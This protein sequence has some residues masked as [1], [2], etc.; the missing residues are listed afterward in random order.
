[1]PFDAVMPSPGTSRW[2][3][4]AD[5]ED[6]RGKVEG[7]KTGG[8]GDDRARSPPP[9][10]RD[11]RSQ[12]AVTASQSGR[13]SQRTLERTDRLEETFGILRTMIGT[14]RNV[15]VLQLAERI[16]GITEVANT[17]PNEIHSPDFPSNGL[18][19]DPAR[20][21]SSWMST[22]EHSRVFWW[23]VDIHQAEAH[24]F[25]KLDPVPAAICAMALLAGESRV[26]AQ[27]VDNCRGY[28]YCF[29][30]IP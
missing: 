10:S 20:P 1:M 24:R 8:E 14:D 6:D 15:D 12:E 30:H 21:G 23:L 29:S 25:L 28:L 9:T 7:V 26:G 22:L 27:V 19:L 2:C 3:I 16:T 17:H 11:R 18:E 5:A 4:P 13:R